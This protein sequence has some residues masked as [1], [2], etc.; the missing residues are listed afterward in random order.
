MLPA[1]LRTT[2][3]NFNLKEVFADMGYLSRS[4]VVHISRTGADPYIPFKHNS[5]AHDDDI[6]LWRKMYHLFQ[7][8]REEFA[9]HYHKRSNVES[10]FAM[11]KAKFRDHIRSRS[12]EA[13][14]NE[15][16]CKFLC[17]NICCVIQ[18]MHELGIDPA[19]RVA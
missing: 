16:L 15:C 13:M 14:I 9:R 3:E 17:H 18:E 7:Y 11:V 8:N 2:A 19:F 6:P 12:D 10:T 4:N 1:L 5:K